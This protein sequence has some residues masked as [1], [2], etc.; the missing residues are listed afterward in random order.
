MS[1]EHGRVP[2]TMGRSF[3]APIKNSALYF[4]RQQEMGRCN[5]PRSKLFLQLFIWLKSAYSTLPTP[6]YLDHSTLIEAY[7]HQVRV[8][9]R[10]RGDRSCDYMHVAIDPEWAGTEG[11]WAV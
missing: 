10:Q 4:Q 6:L 7:G 9:S 5:V 2:M 11:D 8:R 3:L 1:R